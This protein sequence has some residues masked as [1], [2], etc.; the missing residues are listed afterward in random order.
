VYPN[1]KKL[2]FETN[3]HDYFTYLQ[4]TTILPIFTGWWCQK[5]IRI[6]AVARHMYEYINLYIHLCMF[7]YVYL[8]MFVHVYNNI[9]NI[10]AHFNQYSKL[11]HS[12]SLDDKTKKQ[13]RSLKG[14]GMPY[15]WTHTGTYVFM[16]VYICV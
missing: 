16:Y 3:I 12:F 4:Y 11:S 13:N 6:L 5:Q 8:C 2:P 15:L 10:C 1:T 14:Y 9:K 7:V